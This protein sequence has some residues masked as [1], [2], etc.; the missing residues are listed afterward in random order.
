MATIVEAK[1]GDQ[2]ASE[3]MKG[4][5]VIDADTHI[6]EWHDLWTSRAPAS[7]KDRVPRVKL[8]DGTP[9]WVIDDDKFLSL[10]GANCAV[11]RDGSKIKGMRILDFGIEDIHPGAYDVK[12]RL[13]FMDE[14]GT[15]AQIAYP[16]ILGFGGQKAMK[17]DPQL[18]IASIKIFN[19]AM[20]EMQQDSGGRIYPMALLPWWD[21][22]EAVAEIERCQKMGLR[23]I[24]INPDP[25]NHGL[26]SLGREHWYPLWETCVEYD[27]PVNFH[28]GA[29]DESMSWF[30]DTPW[31]E[32][33]PD[34]KMVVGSVM[35]F[36]GNMRV[37]AN[38]LMARFLEKFPQ[39]KIV[40]VESGAAWVPYM[41]EGFE[42]MAG[43]AGVKFE[44]SPSEIFKRQIYVCSLFERRNF[45]ATMRD[46]GV[47]NMMFET[48]FPHGACLYPDWLEYMAQ[49]ICNMTSEERGKFFGGNAARV[50]NIV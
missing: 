49:P 12:A 24:N 37:I 11:K 19:D 38:I 48:D 32:G 46:I 41:L 2:S 28:I 23:G 7:L 26:P 5:K 34:E 8:I 31:P 45:I 15:Y 42:Y 10:G 39:L 40:S 47:D 17:V 27:M 25:H 6:S 44:I 20:A 4:I 50:Y 36:I 35:M 1:P 30:G 22:G 14:V 18:R 3:L 16:N 29:S 43:D 21:I 33:L 9:T 13:A